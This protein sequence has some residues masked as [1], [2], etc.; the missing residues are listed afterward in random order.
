[1]RYTYKCTYK[2]TYKYLA[3]IEAVLEGF[4]LLSEPLAHT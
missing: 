2:Y 4:D 1:M 3:L